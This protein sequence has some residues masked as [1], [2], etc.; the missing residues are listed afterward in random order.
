M[1]TNDSFFLTNHLKVK[2]KSDLYLKINPPPLRWYIIVLRPHEI[3]VGVWHITICEVTC[4]S[5]MNLWGYLSQD[6]QINFEI[7]SD[8]LVLCYYLKLILEKDRLHWTETCYHHR[9]LAFRYSLNFNWSEKYYDLKVR[10]HQD[11][12]GKINQSFLFSVAVTVW[13]PWGM[14]ITYEKNQRH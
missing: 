3:K 6:Q 7:K 10:S 2:S 13:T 1:N 9:W 11:V 4:F 8:Q 14:L 5:S 12:N